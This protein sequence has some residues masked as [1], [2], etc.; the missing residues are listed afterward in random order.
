M[1]LTARPRSK[2]P[3]REAFLRPTSQPAPGVKHPPLRQFK[4]VTHSVDRRDELRQAAQRCPW[5]D[6]LTQSEYVGAPPRHRVQHIADYS[7]PAADAHPR[8]EARRLSIRRRADVGRCRTPVRSARAMCCL[9]VMSTMTHVSGVSRSLPLL[10]WPGQIS[11]PGVLAGPRCLASRGQVSTRERSRQDQ[12]QG[13]AF[14]LR[15]A[16]TRPG[17]PVTGPAACVEL[18]EQGAEL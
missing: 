4:P 8:V 14:R 12:L 6:P 1:Q 2:L 16:R 5:A 11:G 15:S 10:R 9:W 17:S 3:P 18:A 7:H 13:P